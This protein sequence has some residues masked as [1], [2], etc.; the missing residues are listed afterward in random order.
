MAMASAIQVTIT[1]PVKLT[2][3]CAEAI[4]AAPRMTAHHEQM[5]IG[6]SS[7]FIGYFSQDSILIFLLRL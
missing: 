1:E 6:K 4:T 2:M 7:R 5:Q 3:S